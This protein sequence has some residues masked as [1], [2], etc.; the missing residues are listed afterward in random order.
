MAT[1]TALAVAVLIERV[2]VMV[3]SVGGGGSY[4]DHHG[5]VPA[6]RRTF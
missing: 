6:G 5:R 4:D 1:A 3:G 2:R